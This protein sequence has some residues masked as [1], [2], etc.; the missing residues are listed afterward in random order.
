MSDTLTSFNLRKTSQ[1]EKVDKRQVKNNAGGYVFETSL[2]QQVR[3]FIILGTDGGTYYVQPKE[4]TRQV[5]QSVVTLA[6]TDHKTLVD[7]IVEVS[8]GGKAPRQNPAIFALA[9]AASFG[10][11][12]ERNYA[13]SKLADVCRTG[14]HLFL[15]AKYIEQFRGWGRSLRRAVGEW[16]T[17]KSVDEVAYQA[18]KYRSREGWSHR[19]LLRLS[20]PMKTS[21]APLFSWITQSNQ[22][23]LPEIVVGFEK[24]Q[25]NGANIPALITLYGLTWEMLPT[26]A[27]NNREVWEAL[28][29]N[30]LPQTALIRQL[31]RLTNL[32][33]LD[34]FSSTTKKIVSQIT[35]PVRLKKGRVHPF[36]LLVARKTYELG[37]GLKG[38]QAWTPNRKIVDA[39][40]SAFYLAFDA[41]EPTNKNIMYA[42][43]V[44]GSMGFYNIGG[45]PIKPSEASA[46][47]A[48]VLAATEPNHEIYG[49]SDRFRDLG[50]SPKMTLGEATKKI[51]G[52][53]FGSTDCAVPFIEAKK[54]KWDI[55]AVVTMTDSETYVGSIHPF[56]AAKQYREWVGH[57]VKNVVV[58]MTATNFTI[59]DPSD[60]SGLDVVGMD[61][62]VPT[63]I[64]DFIC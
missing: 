48:L 3:R 64:S 38:S 58:G 11:V 28:L 9:I 33:L 31:P 50:I 13:L 7:M 5:A 39:L 54:N 4:L 1:H 40:D 16:Y 44:S 60:T 59:N 45:L 62:S 6:E 18:V 12:D 55:D 8:V 15:F 22:N 2:V 19:D 32:G 52:L 17:E 26:E 23:Y 41:V 34:A 53:T 25:E 51:S 57:D 30:G 27:L 61:T 14:T 29:A 10:D 43:D 37:H 36:N 21:H 46:A 35:D 24:A 20:H 56:Q 63:L 42:L 49:F 47:L